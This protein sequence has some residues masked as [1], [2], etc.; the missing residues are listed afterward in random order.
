MTVWSL[1]LWVLQSSINGTHIA[2][3]TVE[4][5]VLLIVLKSSTTVSSFFIRQYIDCSV[6][7]VFALPRTELNTHRQESEQKATCL[8]CPYFIKLTVRQ[9]IWECLNFWAH[10]YLQGHVWTKLHS[11]S[12]IPTDIITSYWMCGCSKWE[13][14]IF[15]RINLLAREEG[16]F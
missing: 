10:H 8:F 7:K 9:R 6:L 13:W 2:P 14:R 12:F 5:I 3:V 15:K 16:G 11:F 4:N 1:T